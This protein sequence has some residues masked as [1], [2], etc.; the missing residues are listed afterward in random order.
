[1]LVENKNFYKNPFY[2][3]K[4]IYQNF[5]Q[6]APHGKCIRTGIIGIKIQGFIRLFLRLLPMQTASRI[7]PGG[8][9]QLYY[10]LYYRWKRFLPDWGP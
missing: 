10:S 2:M 4:Y 8:P 7:R 5:Y 1:M 9:A 3:L 6:E